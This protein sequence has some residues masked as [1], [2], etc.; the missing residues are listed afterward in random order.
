MVPKKGLLAEKN[1]R[2]KK[3]GQV[4]EEAIGGAAPI[5][6]G[7]TIRKLS[8][9]KAHGNNSNRSFFLFLPSHWHHPFLFALVILLLFLLPLFSQH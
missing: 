8:E 7:C 4:I 9:T 6:G 5:I 2:G 3:R 1:R